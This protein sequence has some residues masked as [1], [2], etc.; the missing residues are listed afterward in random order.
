MCRGPYLRRVPRD[1]AFERLLSVA[2]IYPFR[3]QL[4]GWRFRSMRFGVRYE[5]RAV[6]RRQFVRVPVRI[7]ARLRAN[8]ASE[9]GVVTDLSLGGCA[10]ET[11]AE[12]AVGRVMQ[13]GMKMSPDEATLVVDAAVVRSAHAPNINFE[14]LKMPDESRGR[15]RRFMEDH[16]C[17]YVPGGAAAG[18]TAARSSSAPRRDG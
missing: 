10:I 18:T 11:A 12:A 6:D 7:P 3:C 1:G 5:K 13:L 14:F 9:N 16:F 4:C 8:L 2:W 15:L 17:I